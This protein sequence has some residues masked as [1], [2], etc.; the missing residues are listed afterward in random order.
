MLSRYLSQQMAV[1]NFPFPRLNFRLR[2][3]HL[4]VAKRRMPLASEYCR[5]WSEYGEQM[6]NTRQAPIDTIASSCTV[7]IVQLSVHGIRGML[8]FFA[9][10]IKDAIRCFC[11]TGEFVKFAPDVVRNMHGVQAEIDQQLW[12][13]VSSA[14]R[15]WPHWLL[16][17][18]LL[19]VLPHPLRPVRVPFGPLRRPHR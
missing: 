7:P 17:S 14:H 10:E 3:L 6:T 19:S 18:L 4:A 5:I 9:G 8:H 2:D 15:D 1:A 13:S 12:L 16:A 11:L